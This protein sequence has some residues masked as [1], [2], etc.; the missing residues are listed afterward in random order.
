MRRV[1]LV[2]AAL[3]LGGGAAVAASGCGGSNTTVA[4][5]TETQ[6]VTVGHE[7]SP[8]TST[9]KHAT[10]TTTNSGSTPTAPAS[11]TTGSGAS[12]SAAEATVK[13]KGFTPTV[14]YGYDPKNT[15]G[16]ILASGPENRMQAFFFVNGRYIG[17][18]TKDPS[19][20]ITLQGHDDTSATLGYAVYG[21]NDEACC[22]VKTVKVTY[23][24]DN[25]KLEPQDPIPSSSPSAALS[26]R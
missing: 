1:A 11:A 17:T 21:P 7:T 15:L 3:A 24:L 14:T 4:A 25:G 8:T 13:A 9:S 2:L 10:T 26:R 18:D 20:G 5:I 16:V 22:P 12:A 19:T 6:T 23:A